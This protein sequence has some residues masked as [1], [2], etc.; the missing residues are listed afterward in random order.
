MSS[1]VGIGVYSHGWDKGDRITHQVFI[2]PPAR[3]D[4][5]LIEEDLYEILRVRHTLHDFRD[6]V[7]TTSFTSID[8]L[9]RKTGT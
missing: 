4:L 7:E 5:L 9:V 1:E 6:E 2:H 3:H 8:V